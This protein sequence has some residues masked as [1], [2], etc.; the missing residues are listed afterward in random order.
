[1][2]EPHVFVSYRRFDG[3]EIAEIVSGRLRG[4]WSGRALRVFR[5][6][7]NL[8][9]G[10]YAP[11]IDR[12]VRSAPEFALIL[13]RGALQRL[14]EPDSVLRSELAAAYDSGSTIH[15]LLH[16]D[17]PIDRVQG[18]PLGDG[19]LDDLDARPYA[20]EMMRDSIRRYCQ[21]FPWRLG[22]I[23]SILLLLAVALGVYVWLGSQV[24]PAVGWD[25]EAHASQNGNYLE[26]HVLAWPVVR[27]GSYE[28]VDSLIIIRRSSGKDSEHPAVGD[29]IGAKMANAN[30]SLKSLAF[31]NLKMPVL[32]RS[33]DNARPPNFVALENK[34][35]SIS[36]ED[37][38]RRSALE[39]RKY[40][41][42]GLFGAFLVR[43][44][45]RDGTQLTL[46][47]GSP[48]STLAPG[49][50]PLD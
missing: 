35:R 45:F 34:S 3:T 36:E 15:V 41:R 19:S 31:K 44:V 6:T 28:D 30:G 22:W 42:G 23:R 7:E 24:E 43:I 46:D 10:E 33:Y 9:P 29:D 2:A 4:G 50:E 38:E 32:A 5:D 12:A 21:R 17:V 39:F 1:M 16:Q 27:L 37:G 11:E 20:P 14:L 18:V 47:A 8:N 40:A 25:Y 48:L 26:R 13:T 49:V